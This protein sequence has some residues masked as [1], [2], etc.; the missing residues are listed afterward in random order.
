MPKDYY[1]TLGVEK[2]ASPE[3]LK[4]AF[5]ALAH[6]YHPDKGGDPEKFKEVNEAF[7]VL[8]DPQKRQRY[9]QFGSAAFEQGGM[10]GAGGFPGG[11]NSSGA[12]F[13]D[14]SDL[15]GEMFGSARASGRASRAEDIQVDVQLSFR[16][17]AFGATRDLELYKTLSCDRCSGSGAE[18]GTGKTICKTCGGS[19]QVT[20]NQRTIFGTFQTRRPCA[21]CRGQGSVVEKP[22]GKC[23]GSGAVKGTRK[24]R[25]TIPAGIDDGEL[26]RLTG[27]GESGGAG[28]Q[29]GD[30]YVRVRVKKDAEFERDGNDLRLVREI[31]F[32]TAGLGGSVTVATL[33]GTAE[34]KIP[35]GT[36]SGTVFRLRGKGIV[37]PRTGA[38]GDQYVQVIIKTP[39][40]LSKEQKKL[41][42]DLDLT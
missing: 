2:G 40:K 29:P 19:G 42:E 7:Q 33:E 3:E 12:G 26:I 1:K 11:F 4:K 37:D 30:L 23:R 25:V 31:G 32:S 14:L 36:Q 41:L 35:A 28:S 5:R 10:G 8:G 34:L 27:E 39:E 13:E 24:L 15:F 22:C 9:D 17:A 6:K 16:E 18:P 38:I 21:T 20:A